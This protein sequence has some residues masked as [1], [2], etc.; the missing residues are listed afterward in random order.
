[1]LRAI[2]IVEISAISG[3]IS[4]VLGTVFGGGALW[5]YFQRQREDAALSSEL[6]EKISQAMFDIINLSNTY[7]SIRDK[8]GDGN[9]LVEL[10]QCISLLSDDV[11]A[12]E[13]KLAKIEG[14]PPRN[15]NTNFIAPEPVKNLRFKFEL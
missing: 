10:H 5:K 8:E 13:F 9:R 4:F 11:E 15:I 7:C 1:M 2:E 12:I 3:S 6:R 14:R